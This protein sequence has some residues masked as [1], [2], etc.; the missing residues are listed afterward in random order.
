MGTLS[1]YGVTVE[2][3]KGKGGERE[4]GMMESGD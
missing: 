1:C 3:A 2:W 4:E